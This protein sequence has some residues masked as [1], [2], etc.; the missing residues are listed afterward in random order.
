MTSL[1]SEILFNLMLRLQKFDLEVK[2]ILRM[3]YIL[4]K[5]IIAL[6]VDALSR[7]DTTKGFIQG[8]NLLTYF[9]FY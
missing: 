7:D 2:I 9:P 6:G 5:Q 4:G 8:I 3:I 1:S